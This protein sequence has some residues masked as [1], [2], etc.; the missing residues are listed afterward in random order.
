MNLAAVAQV[1]DL[2]TLAFV[3][4]ATA[5]FFF[6]QSPVLL[7]RLGRERFVPLQMRLTVVLFKVLGVALLLMMGTTL[8]HSP[9]ASM[10]TVTAALALAGGLINRYVV[11]PRALRAGGRSIKGL[12]GNDEE[13][14]TAGFASEGAGHETR[15]LHRLVVLFV[16]IM[17]AGVVGHGVVL[18][19]T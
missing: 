14:S 8:V 5:W 13:G 17:L 4:G 15:L 2:L 12:A 9:L 7:A 19:G 16:V 6:V 3:F 10:A 1:L 11:V 18:L